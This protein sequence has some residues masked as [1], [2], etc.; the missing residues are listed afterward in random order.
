M[1]IAT[2][3]PKGSGKTLHGRELAKTLGIFHVDFRQR[4]QEMLMRKTK[5][6]R[7]TM[8]AHFVQFD[9]DQ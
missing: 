4:L 3:G 5:V 1:R 6:S 9:V 8:R 7:N 2:I